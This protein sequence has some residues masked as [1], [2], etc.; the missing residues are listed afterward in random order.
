MNTVYEDA[1]LTIFIEELKGLIPEH[2]DELCVTKDFPL[3]PDYEAYEK[4]RQLN[5]LRCITCRFDGKLIG[6]IIF[7]IQPH[8]HYKTCKTAF[9]D[10]Y[11]IKKE[12][13]Q[14]RIGIKLFTYAEKVLRYCGVNRIILHTKVH[15]DNSRLFEYLKYKHTD[16]MFTKVLSTEQT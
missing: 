6:Y 15:L 10:M 3:M 12:Y 16:K 14:G 7:I 8:L 2:Y 13:R 4:L 5:M 11:F 1:D 9:E